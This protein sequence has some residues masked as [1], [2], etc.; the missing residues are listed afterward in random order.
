MGGEKKISKN[1]WWKSHWEIVTI[2]IKGENSKKKK[3][4]EFENHL[5]K[6]T[7]NWR[8]NTKKGG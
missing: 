6:V 2:E 7:K 8:R 5:I 4:K 3:E 1:E